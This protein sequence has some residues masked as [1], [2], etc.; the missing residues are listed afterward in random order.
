MANS[1]VLR[2]NDFYGQREDRRESFLEKR[3]RNLIHVITGNLIRHGGHRSRFIELVNSLSGELE[4]AE[5]DANLLASLRLQARKQGVTDDYMAR[6][7]ALVRIVAEREVGL[8]H[9][10]EQLMG[11]WAMMKGMVAEMDTGQGKTLTATLIASAAALA[12]FPTHVITVNE[13]LATRDAEAMRP[14]YE[15]LGLTVGCVLNRMSPVE[16]QRGYQCDITYCTNKQVAF[17]Y[18]RDRVEVGM[19]MSQR[20][21]E[22]ESLYATNLQRDKLLLRGLYFAIVD[23][24]DSILIDEAVTPLVISTSVTNESK[25]RVYEKALGFARHLE[26]PVDYIIHKDINAV[27]LTR[28]GRDALAAW[29]DLQGGLWKSDVIREELISQ[30]IRAMEVFIKDRH[31]LVADN[32]V[33]I[34]DEFTGRLMPDRNWEGGLHQMIELKEGCEMTGDKDTL[35]RISYQRFFRR[36]LNLSGMTGTAHEVRSEIRSVYNM[37]VI[38]IPPAQKVMRTIAKDIVCIDQETKWQRI[39]NRIIEVHETGQ[40]ILVGT[41]SVESSEHLSRLLQQVNMP[42]QLLN[43]RQDEDEA[44]IIAKAG[45]S[46]SVTVATNMAGRGTDIKLTGEVKGL[47]G[48][49]VIMTER[50]DS[51]RIDRQLFG[52]CGRQ[53]DP[54]SVESYISFEDELVRNNLPEFFSNFVVRLLRTNHPVAQMLARSLFAMAQKRVE[55]RQYKARRQVLKSDEQFGGLLAFTGR[56]E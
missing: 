17:D 22:L 19:R 46:G 9:F 10:D 35:A 34:V 26:S 56:M 24:A 40:P 36:Y 27:E 1:F 23:E 44:N 52:R 38:R 18:L 6:V 47:G 3:L 50:H 11:G 15:K 49:H 25:Q 53:G 43:A 45:V 20:Q 48:L 37:D 31:Y 12:G 55:K 51:R 42:H 28:H 39:V 33:Q 32:K 8:R 41:R 21:L 16:K 4:R 14:I 7:F 13:Y 30:A 5:V 54:G 2:Y 29:G